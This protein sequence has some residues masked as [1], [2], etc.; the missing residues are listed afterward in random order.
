MTTSVGRPIYPSADIRRIEQAAGEVAP[1][2]ME[3][4]GLAA[5]ELARSLVADTGKDVLV[6]A[7]P[8]N[9]GGDARIAAER[10]REMFFRVTLATTDEPPPHDRRWG[11]VI[12]GLFGIGLA[13]PLE[14]ASSRAGLDESRPKL[15]AFLK[16]IHARPAYQ[17]AL[18]KG[19]KYDLL[20]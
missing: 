7:G 17:R 20:K 4:A 1:S 8:G 6:L 19:G 10:L 15:W 5:A 13:R 11:L 18:E 16:T 12:D 14:A 2:L 3:R 9:N